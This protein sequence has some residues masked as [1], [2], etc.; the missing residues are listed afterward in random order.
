MAKDPSATTAKRDELLAERSKL[1]V[2][3]NALSPAAVCFCPVG[4][5]S[6]VK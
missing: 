3:G 4:V 6:L 2:R 1:Q 5:E